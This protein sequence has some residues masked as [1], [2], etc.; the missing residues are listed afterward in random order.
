[1]S[2]VLFD[3]LSFKNIQQ[4]NLCSSFY[5]TD[6]KIKKIALYA[7]SSLLIGGAFAIVGV[8]VAGCIT[9]PLAFTAIA[10]LALG[11]ILISY[12][13]DLKDYEDPKE[14]EK[15]RQK[16]LHDPFSK[17]FKEH[18]L[19]KVRTYQIVSPSLLQ[20]KFLQE[21]E[22][23][24]FSDLLKK[25]PLRTLKTY[26]L[27]PLPVLQKSFALEIQGMDLSRFLRV[28][29]IADL[30][31]YQ[32]VSEKHLLAF[33]KLSGRMKS[34]SEA[35][36]ALKVELDRKYPKRQECL[37]AELDKESK[38]A[39]QK[40]LELK[41]EMASDLRSS[42]PYAYAPYY[43]GNNVHNWQEYNRI[44]SNEVWRRELTTIP[45]IENATDRILRGELERID[46]KKQLLKERG[47]GESDQ[48]KY[49]AEF[50][51]MG[52]A[53]TTKVEA[54]QSEFRIVQQAVLKEISS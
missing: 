7:I 16:A 33:E 5:L 9:W 51:S 40:A 24:S 52:K 46:Q 26:N 38:R 30:R 35:F 41:R 1:M 22:F 36:D 25:Y 17:I 39:R 13:S 53:Y 44:R 12:A 4:E 42:D 14:L 20:Q 11:M 34:E 31:S 6:V 18:S 49:N 37:L 21:Y 27:M 54:I 43:Y 10:P 48:M 45:V 3:N 2:A 19:E 50:R 28:F 32:I 15:M 23:Y 47:E 8:S 29:S